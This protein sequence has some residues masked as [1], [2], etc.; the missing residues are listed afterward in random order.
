MALR[1]ICP[2]C[3]SRPFTEFF[4]GGEVRRLASST[5][6]LDDDYR[7]VWLPENLAGIQTERWFH[8]AGCRRWLTLERDTLTNEVHGV[9]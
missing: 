9:R 6:T 8:S 3:G 4:F 5:D 2:H 7:R 1:I